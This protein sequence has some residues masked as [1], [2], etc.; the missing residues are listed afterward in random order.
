MR[1]AYTTPIPDR[2][3]AIGAVCMYA[4]SL[5]ASRLANHFR[6]G[7]GVWISALV[8]QYDKGVLVEE[9]Y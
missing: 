9:Y 5:R 6:I 4:F 3:I 1:L 2:I 7:K 8:P